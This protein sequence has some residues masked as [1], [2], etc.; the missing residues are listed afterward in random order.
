MTQPMRTAQMVGSLKSMRARKGVMG[1]AE[2]IAGVGKRQLT[3]E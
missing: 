3:L 1:L 2:G